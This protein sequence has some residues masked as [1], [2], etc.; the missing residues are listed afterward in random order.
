MAMASDGRESTR[1]DFAVAVQMKFTVVRVALD[2]G[3]LHAPE[4]T[5][6]RMIACRDRASSGGPLDVVHLH[7]DRLGFGLPDPD[8]QQTRPALLLEDDYVRLLRGSTPS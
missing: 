4:P 1:S 2:P 7:D 5:V 6:S 3:D 8:R